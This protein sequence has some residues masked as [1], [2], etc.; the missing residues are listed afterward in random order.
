MNY[1]IWILFLVSLACNVIFYYYVQ[2]LVEV[3][4]EILEDYETENERVFRDISTL[5]EHYE[6]D[7]NMVNKLSIYYEDTHLV[8]LMKKTKQLQDEVR[9]ICENINENKK[10]S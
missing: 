8:A 6:Q 4:K 10:E 3:N 9:E 7:L 2:H 1:V 5:L